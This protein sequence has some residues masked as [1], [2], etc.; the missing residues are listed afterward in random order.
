M[1]QRTCSSQPKYQS[2]VFGILILNNVF[3]EV[4]V[5]FRVMLKDDMDAGSCQDVIGSYSPLCNL[6]GLIVDD[7]FNSASSGG[8]A[9]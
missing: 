9:V 8:H 3:K 1:L 6:I 2:F 4:E 7:S 5:N